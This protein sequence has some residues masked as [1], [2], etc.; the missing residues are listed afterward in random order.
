MRAAMPPSVAAT[1][2]AHE[3]GASAP[4]GA[5]AG[6]AAF[7]AVPAAVKEARAPELAGLWGA[8][9]QAVQPSSA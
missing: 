4:A 7:R 1:V 8:A 6:G 5:V 9:P 2:S 3:A